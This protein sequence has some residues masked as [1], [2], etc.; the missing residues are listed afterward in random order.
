[1]KAL[2]FVLAAA[3]LAVGTAAQA[4][5]SSTAYRPYVGVGVASAGNITTDSRHTDAKIF[6]GVDF[7]NNWG[8]EAGYVDFS[9]QDIHVSSAIPNTSGTTLAT[10]G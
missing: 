2:T 5:Q 10:K 9:S 7:S 6:G 3:A 8:V 1:M 4:Q